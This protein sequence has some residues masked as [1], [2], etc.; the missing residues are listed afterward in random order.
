MNYIY[1]ISTAKANITFIKIINVLQ[2]MLKVIQDATITESSAG[3]VR[4]MQ[5]NS[6]HFWTTVEAPPNKVLAPSG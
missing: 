1:Q 3:G 2:H 5:P 4:P 6:A